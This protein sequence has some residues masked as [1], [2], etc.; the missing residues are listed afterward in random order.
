MVFYKLNF[1]DMSKVNKEFS[2]RERNDQSSENKVDR[3]ERFL[4]ERFNFRYNEV[5]RETE[6]SIKDKNEFITIDPM[7]FNDLRLDLERNNFS[8]SVGILDALLKSNQFPKRFNPFRDYFEGLPKWDGT[9]YIQLLSSF[10]DLRDKTKSDWFYTMFKKHLMRTVACSLRMLPFNKHCFVFLGKQNDGKSYLVRYLCPPELKDYYKEN[11]P[12]D[13]KDSIL[14]LGQNFI[15]SLD[16]LHD[17]NKADANKVKSLFSQTD[18]KVREHYAVKDSV[19]QR[20]ASFFGTTN[21]REFLNDVT[22]NVRWLVFEIDGIRHDHGKENGYGQRVSAERVWSQAYH[23]VLNGA[24]YVLT[25]DEI[26]EVEKQNRFYQKTSPEMDLISRFFAPSEKGKPQTI[27][28]TATDILDAIQSKGNTTVKL[29]Q[30]QI[31]KALTFLGFEK[32]S[33]R[34][35]SGENPVNRYLITSSDSE[36]LNYLHSKVGYLATNDV[37]DIKSVRFV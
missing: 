30:V 31:G 10:I 15:I 34:L 36:I 7:A 32:H 3:L 27:P 6:Y 17:M 13:H 4:N 24:S 28:C 14:A 37:N 26:R 21:E 19:Q 12:L 16:E 25:T 2:N 5:T 29:S 9:D 22:G 33:I 20:Y 23:E 11:P 1:N 35:Q 8:G 18:T